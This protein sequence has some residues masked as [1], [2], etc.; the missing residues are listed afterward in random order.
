MRRRKFIAGLAAAA[1]FPL[2]ARAEQTSVPVVFRGPQS[3]GPELAINL[4]TAKTLGIVV[5]PTILAHADD[6][7]E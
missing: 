5:P 7:I 4:K 6:V 1:A 3:P 2:A